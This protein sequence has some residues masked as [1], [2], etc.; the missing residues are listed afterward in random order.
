MKKLICFCCGREFESPTTE[1][2]ISD[3][4]WRSFFCSRKCRA[5]GV[6]TSQKLRIEK[7]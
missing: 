3:G 4:I 5:Q 1:Q 2:I 6:D 7:K